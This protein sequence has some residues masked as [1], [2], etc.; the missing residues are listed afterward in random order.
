MAPAIVGCELAFWLLILAGLLARYRWQRSRASAVLLVGA[1]VTDVVLLVLLLI[2]LRSGAV[3]DWSHGLAAV[4]L[5]VSVV[6]GR[7]LV[8]AADRRFRGAPSMPGPP[9]DVRAAWV[10]F[11][12][13]AAAATL[14]AAILLGCIALVGDPHRTAALLGWLPNLGLVVAVWLVHPVVSTLRDRPERS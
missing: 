12:R 6:F 1:P 5:G 8:A 3:A 14:S 2:D 10:L 9:A 4:Y 13:V 7:D 11:A